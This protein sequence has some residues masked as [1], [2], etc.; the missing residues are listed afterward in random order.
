LVTTVLA[1]VAVVGVQ[2]AVRVAD[3]TAS[4]GRSDSA[5]T[6][7]GPATAEE[8]VAQPETE[9][10]PEPEP[11]A[12][13]FP[14]RPEKKTGI[15]TESGT[16]SGL[17]EDAGDLAGKAQDLID[18]EDE[19]EPAPAPPDP[20]LDFVVSTFNVLGAGHTS[21]GGNKPQ[22]ASG[23]QRLGRQ[24]SMLN[25]NGVEVVGFQEFEPSQ[26]HSFMRRTRGAWGVYPAMSK[27]RAAVRNSIAWR[28]SV[29]DL[30]DYGT[31]P[32]PYFR[33]KIVP[34]PV[35]L[36]THKQTKRQVWLINVH[37]PASSSR[38][39]NNERWRDE[40]TRR[41][42]AKVRSLRARAPQVPVILMGDFN[43]RQEVY[44]KVTARGDIDAANPG[45]DR[46]GCAPPALMGIDWIFGTRDIGFSAYRRQSAGGASDHPMIVSRAAVE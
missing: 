10:E 35:I 44:C 11:E 32:I 46:P 36:L 3:D 15:R 19:E 29:W 6:G 22:M 38:R 14:G 26:Y 43:E 21:A 13:T 17:G 30:A 18:G 23:E 42:V 37:N 31:I 39:G 24:I 1:V 5:A 25:A 41:Q 33:G 16:T 8:S 7:T 4:A 27:G 2:A 28:R 9:A 40:A 45:G 12:E 20:P 34:M